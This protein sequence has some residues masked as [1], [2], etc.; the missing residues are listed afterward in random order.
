VVRKVVTGGSLTLKIENVISLIWS[1]EVQV[2]MLSAEDAYPLLLCPVQIVVDRRA[3]VGQ[4]R[5][6]SH[7][8]VNQI[9]TSV[10]LNFSDK[11]HSNFKYKFVFFHI[12]LF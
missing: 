9:M 6:L 3:T 1:P 2:S 7:L 5:Y 10:L 11:A 8:A 12:L 4:P